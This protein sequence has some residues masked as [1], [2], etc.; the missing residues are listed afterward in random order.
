MISCLLSCAHQTH[1]KINVYHVLIVAYLYIILYLYH[2]IIIMIVYI[3][4]IEWFEKKK[5]LLH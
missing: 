4:L 3:I 5:L 2:I 1:D